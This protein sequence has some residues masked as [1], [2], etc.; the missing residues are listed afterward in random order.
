MLVITEKLN[1]FVTFFLD[2][3]SNQKNQGFSF[4][5]T[6]K[7]FIAPIILLRSESFFTLLN[8]LKCRWSPMELSPFLS[9]SVRA[10]NHF[11]KCR[12]S[13]T[14]IFWRR[15]ERERFWFEI[16]IFYIH[17]VRESS[18]RS[19]LDTPPASAL[20][21]QLTGDLR[22]IGDLLCLS[23]TPYPKRETYIW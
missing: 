8:S 20:Q 19:G 11:M 9:V 4:N 15:W 21:P 23:L 12:G 10:K 22:L 5:L 2:E 6:H 17:N 16:Y 18:M 1:C 7:S 14:V 13:R 3:K